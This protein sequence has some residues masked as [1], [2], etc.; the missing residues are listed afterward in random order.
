MFR[1]KCLLIIGGSGQL[2]QKTVERF[3]LQQRLKRW[4]V[5]NIDAVEN[6][7]ATENFVIDPTQPLQEEQM[8]ELHEKLGKF[9]E[10]FEMMINTAGHYYPPNTEKA[11][12]IAN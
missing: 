4:K 8:A 10:E 3:A 9:D 11:I 12:N 2:G 5:F 6:P 1:K 7:H